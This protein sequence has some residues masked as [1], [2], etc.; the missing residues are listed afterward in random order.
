MALRDFALL[1]L[2]ASAAAQGAHKF[3]R[4]L[5]RERK[6]RAMP[7][8]QQY[9]CRERERLFYKTR[10]EIVQ[11]DAYIFACGQKRK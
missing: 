3:N 7:Q 10:N 11:W 4:S 2:I 1:S 9:I 6:A 8:Q 5:A